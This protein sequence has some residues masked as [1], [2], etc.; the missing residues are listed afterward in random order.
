MYSS[1]NIYTCLCILV[2]NQILIHKCVCVYVFICKYIHM[3]MYTCIKSN[4]H[5]HEAHS[6]VPWLIHMCHDSF[7]C[8]MTHS[9]VPW[10]THEAHSYVT[11]LIHM[12]HDSFATDLLKSDVTLHS[13]KSNPHTNYSL[14]HLR[15]IS[16]I[17][18]LNQLSTSLRLFRLKETN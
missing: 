13:I 5:T 7:T 9:H 11:W 6:Y 2:L 16:L 1:V 15:F 18:S 17:S 14:L 12:C 3:S 4:P 10:H 8:A